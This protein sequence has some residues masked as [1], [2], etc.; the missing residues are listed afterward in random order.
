LCF[1][2]KNKPPILYDIGHIRGIVGVRGFRVRVMFGDWE[3]KTR[4]VF[5]GVLGAMDH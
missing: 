1:P 2:A 4:R 5:S 3:F